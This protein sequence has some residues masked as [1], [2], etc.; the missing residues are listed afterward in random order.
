ME[1]GRT[2]REGRHYFEYSLLISPGGGTSF[3]YLY[4]ELYGLNHDAVQKYTENIGIFFQK[5]KE[6]A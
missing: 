3:L 4:L 5:L 1:N 6:Y 2:K